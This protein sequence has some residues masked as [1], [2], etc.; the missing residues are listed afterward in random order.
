MHFP[1]ERSQTHS[2][3]WRARRGVTGSRLATTISRAFGA[4]ASST[5]QSSVRD[6][7]KSEA[8]ITAV[9]FAYHMF[10]AQ[11]RGR[12]LAGWGEAN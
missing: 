12:G 7:S 11:V 9:H 2:P 3:L 6:F 4:D 8:E 10:G 5:S 1:D